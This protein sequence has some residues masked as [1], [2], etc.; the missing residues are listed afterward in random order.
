VSFAQNGLP[1]RTVIAEDDQSTSISVTLAIP[2]IN[3]PLV[4]AP[5]PASQTVTVPQLRK[6]ERRARKRSRHGVKS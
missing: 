2:A 1:V 4:I 6:L 3:F 5:P